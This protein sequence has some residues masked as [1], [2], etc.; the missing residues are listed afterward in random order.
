VRVEHGR[1]LLGRRRRGRQPHPHHA[2]AG[3]VGQVD[4]GRQV[5]AGVDP[6]G[7]LRLPRA[8]AVQGA[9]E[10]DLAAAPGQVGAHVARQRGRQLVRRPGHRQQQPAVDLQRQAGGAADGVVEHGGTPGDVGL[11]H[12]LRGQVGDAV[13]GE[14]LAQPVLERG[15]PVERDAGDGGHGRRA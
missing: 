1:G 2:A 4:P 10:P 15:D 5:E 6:L 7:H 3:Q 9:G 8:G 11:P 14:L 13:G 12:H